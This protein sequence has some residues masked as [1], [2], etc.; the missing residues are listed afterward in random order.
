MDV[1]YSSVVAA[2]A[3]FVLCK[4]DDAVVITSV[5]NTK[6]FFCYVTRALLASHARLGQTSFDSKQLKSKG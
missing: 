4:V 6:Y 3:A 2:A 1:A 5:A